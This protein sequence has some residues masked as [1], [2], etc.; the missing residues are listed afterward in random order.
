V[1]N[2]AD[3]DTVDE[4][5]LCRGHSFVCFATQNKQL[6]NKETQMASN[7]DATK[8][9]KKPKTDPSTAIVLQMQNALSALV[10]PPAK[11]KKAAPKDK[12]KSPA[13][14]KKTKKTPAKRTTQE[15]K[16]LKQVLVGIAGVITNVLAT[17][18]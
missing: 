4:I 1:V 3:V 2:H 11:K 17:E 10:A 12:A 5:F 16:R 9:P 14:V 7:E 6:P 15:T 8:K 18:K 13:G